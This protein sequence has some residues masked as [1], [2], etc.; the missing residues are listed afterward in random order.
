MRRLCGA[1]PC[2]LWGALGVLAAGLV[3]TALASLYI[4]AE[5]ESSAQREF[6]FTSNETRLEIEAR[7]KA[8]AQILR[9]G[10]A[11][12][13]ASETVSRDA[14]RTFTRRLEIDQHLPGIQ[15][16]GFAS[17][18]PRA[19]LEQH[20]QTIRS[21]GFP[22]YQVRPAGERET[23]SAIIYLEPFEDRNLRAFGYDML[24]EPVRRAA[25]ERARDEYT[26]ALSG[27]VTLV[28]ETDKDVQA[29]VLMYVPVYR[30]GV[31]LETLAQRRAAI[32]GWVYSPYR[33]TDLMRGT[34]WH[35]DRGQNDRQILLQVYDG[36]MSTADTLLYDSEGA[37]GKSPA[38]TARVARLIPVD[39][40][41]HRWT[42]RFTYPG[43]LAAWADYGSVWL[44]LFGG[45]ISSL[46][47]SGLMLWRLQR[48]RFYRER[49]EAGEALRDSEERYRALVE[50]SADGILI[51]D[52]ETKMFKFANPAMCRML[53]YTEHELKTLGTPNIV[54]KDDLPRAVAEFEAQARGEKT[55]APDIPLLRK[56]GTRFIVDVNATTIPFGGRLSML[57]IFRDITERKR[58]EAQLRQQQNL[59]STGTLARG[60]AHEINNP[61]MGIM[62]YAELIKDEADGN[63]SLAAYATE[64]IAEGRRV[65]RMTQSL[66]GYTEQRG[67]PA[68]ETARLED[69]VAAV[70][71]PAAEAAREK[72]IAVSCDIPAD[73]PPVSCRRSQ[74]EQVITAL[75]AN[76]M[77]AWDMNIQA[78]AGSKKIRFSAREMKGALVNGHSSLVNDQP[79]MTND[80]PKAYLTH[81]AD[82]RVRS[83]RLTVEDNGP[84]IP[85]AIRER[86]FDPFFT[87]KDRTKHAGLGLWI[88]RSLAQEHGGELMFESETGHGTRFHMD[89]PVED[90][91]F[92]PLE[93]DCHE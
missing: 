18:I 60:M 35:W 24:S 71:P 11:L 3:V 7:L 80:A 54:P 78:H 28:Q 86:V 89:L 93:K 9:S 21:E 53:G 36:D 40:A 85:A 34:L 74:L 42:L 19:Q 26:A 91:A 57:G 90:N 2:N 14:W 44:V 49:A 70:L 23:Y 17:L 4:K 67:T 65:A 30:H 45:T 29:G 1:E 62:N 88:S 12:F 56:D 84:G 10:V 15:G 63:A 48:V 39:F 76:A 16:I 75:L 77:E 51:A 47:L 41:G 68:F 5:V 92:G 22:D 50:K 33:M 87:T 52:L 20:V 37:T 73:L 69:L 38:S 43:G 27:K 32:L 79:P 61:I 58:M 13:D 81:D 25:M 31:P 82:R 64:I 8:G 6:D 59:V 46:L 66:L 72:G 83:V 55:V